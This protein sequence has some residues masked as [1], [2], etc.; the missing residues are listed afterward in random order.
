[1]AGYVNDNTSAG[2]LHEVQIILDEV[3]NTG[4]LKSDGIEHSG[5]ALS[6]SYTGI[7]V[8]RLDGKT[9]GRDS[10]KNREVIIFC[11]LTAKITCA[12]C[13]DQRALEAYIAYFN[14]Q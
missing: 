10:A 1:M 14:V 11:E 13:K 2:F 4:I 8:S 5:S 6:N 3:M 7:A 12:G 9:L